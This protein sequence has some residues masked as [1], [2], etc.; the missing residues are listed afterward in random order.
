MDRDTKQRKQQALEVVEELA[1]QINPE[2]SSLELPLTTHLEWDLGI[3]SLERLELTQRLEKALQC[4]LP[5]QAIFSANTLNELLRV[6]EN[7]EEAGD[8]VFSPRL[9]PA[10]ESLPPF[11]L[12]SAS[13]L[14]AL[15]YQAQHQRDRVLLCLEL[16]GRLE[17]SLTPQELLEEAGS[18]AGGLAALGVRAGDRVGIMLPTGLPF[19]ATFFAVQWL[20]AVPVPLYPPFRPDQAEDYVR[21]QAA[22]LDNAGVQILVSFARAWTMAQLLRLHSKSLRELVSAD[23]L[24]CAQAPPRHPARLDELGL[25]QYTSGSTGLPKGVALT[26]ANLLHNLQAYGRALQVRSNDVVVSWLPLYHD[27]GLIG[28]LLGSLYHGV[29][30][31][32]MGPQDFLARPSR[33]LWAIHHYQGTISPAPNFAYE[34]CARKIPDEELE[35]LDLSSWRVA[36][37]G[38]EPV[39]LDTLQRFSQRYGPMGFREQ[40]HFPAYGLAEAALAVAFSPLDRAPKVDV[41]S[42]PGLEREQLARAPQ[43]GEAALELVSSGVALHGTEL[44]VRDGSG[45]VLEDRLEGQ[46]F[47]RS[48][49]SLQSYFGNPEATRAIKDESGWVST[50]DLAYL[51]QGELYITGRTK[52]IIVKAGRNLHPQDIEQVVAEVDGVRRG[53]VAAFGVSQSQSGSE[54]LVV[55]FES[56]LRGSQA[57]K[58]QSEVQRRVAQAVGVSIDQVLAVAPGLL[59]KTPSGKIRRKECQQRFQQGTLGRKSGVLTQVARLL[60]GSRNGRQQLLQMPGQVLRGIWNVGSLFG[61]VATPGLLLS[62]VAP[63]LAL[64]LLP[65]ASRLWLRVSGLSLKVEGQLPP[66]SSLVVSNHCSLID[67]LVLMAATGRPMKF[68]VAPW[69]YQHP[70]LS[71]GLRNMGHLP[72][73]RGDTEGASKLTRE[74][75]AALRAGSSV[76]TFPEGGIET[77][78]GLRPFAL[79][80]FQVAVENRL[81]VVPV[82]LRGTRIALPWPKVVVKPTTIVVNIGPPLQAQGD[83][84]EHALQLAQESRQWIGQHCAEAKV[85]QRLRRQD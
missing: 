64:R 62:H 36:L 61:L 59:P 41:I 55:V 18:L 26:H 38:A 12:E 8:Q 20:G 24:A 47:F 14:E 66:G 34:V 13:C 15:A 27:M 75:V 19:V 49:S 51:D 45:R 23:S 5:A 17:R 37:N 85:Q 1:L 35:G 31:V 11:P 84:W 50:G 71:R 72:V 44:Q 70:I 6:V 79:G 46:L 21:R 9:P 60:A 77:S 28:S 16:D 63:G 29:P 78:P 81:P 73:T 25:I 48:G 53:C 42:Q 54:Q 83:Q 76:A 67:A 10:P 74:V 82:S 39:R 52:D 68:L 30:L 58:L 65:A 4:R 7:P 40:S 56:R 33:W 22:I 3:G 32:L 2:R 69:I 57:K 43:E 80:V